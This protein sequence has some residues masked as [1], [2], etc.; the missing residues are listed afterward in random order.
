MHNALGEVKM[1]PPKAEKLTPTHSW[2]DSQNHKLLY[3]RRSSPVTCREQALFFP[4]FKA[5]LAPLW[6]ARTPNHFPWIAWQPETPFAQRYL[7]GVAHRVEFTHDCR[8]GD[9]LEPFVAICRDIC[10]C[11]LGKRPMRNRPAHHRIDA[12]SLGVCAALGK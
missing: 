10:A 2:F 6:H 7:D 9:V 3:K 4:V 5:P 8:R 12:R 11:E 1:L